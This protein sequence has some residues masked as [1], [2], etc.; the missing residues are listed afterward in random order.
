MTHRISFLAL[1]VLCA[2]LAPAAS[3]A[4]APTTDDEKTVYVIGVNLAHQLEPLALKPEEL[5]MLFAGI[6]DQ[7]TGKPLAASVAEYGPKVQQLVKS[8]SATV[9]AEEK[10]AS[11]AFLAAEAAAP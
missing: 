8:R 11:A 6:R 4:K 5:E 2:G 7:V 9:L 3:G 10:K 1:A